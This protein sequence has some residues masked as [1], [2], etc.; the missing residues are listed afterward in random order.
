MTKEQILKCLAVLKEVEKE[1]RGN[2][3]LDTIIKTYEAEI[4]EMEKMEK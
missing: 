4:R 1:F 3:N 2:M